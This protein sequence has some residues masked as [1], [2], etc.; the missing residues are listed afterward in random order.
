MH[1]QP[2]PITKFTVV[3]F[4]SGKEMVIDIAAVGELV[5]AYLTLVPN[6]KRSVR[7][8]LLVARFHDAIRDMANAEEEAALKKID[9]KAMGISTDQ[10]DEEG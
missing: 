5:T 4:H 3:G 2:E 1:N 6:E 8:A 7:G 9:K 10:L